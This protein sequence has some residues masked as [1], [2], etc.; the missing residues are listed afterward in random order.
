MSGAATSRR[1]APPEAGPPP[2]RVRRALGITLI[3]GASLSFAL[4]DTN[5]KYLGQ[6][7]PVVTILW[8]RYAVQALV[9]AVWLGV[10]QA[11]SGRRM[12]VTAHPRFQALRGSLLLLCSALLFLGVQHMPVAEYTAV[13]M[14]TP[15]VATV[16][17]A[18]FLHE[19]LT[20][21]RAALVV[22]GFAGALTIV[23]PGSALFGWFLVFPLTMTLA[24]AVFQLLTRKLAGLE[25]PLTTHF[26]TG[27]VGGVVMTAVMAV[28]PGDTWRALAAAT[29]PQAGLVLFAGLA[30]TLGHLCLILALGMAPMAALMPFTY[31]QIAFAS[32][33][34]WVVFHHVPDGWAVTGMAIVA[35]C[36]AA[37]V[38][39][40]LRDAQHA[41]AAREDAAPIAD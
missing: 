30:G 10:L 11:R 16:L 40:N 23:R 5:A 35:A 26:Y 28:A 18:L 29:P 32:L 4:L 14:L 6:H 37:A 9:M 21:L 13:G 12:F 20:P 34:G 31:T 19:R 15:V 3:L 17:A 24:Y 1:A 27:L 2:P 8:G 33:A 41:R 38:W 22:G 7:L 36:G 39:L 25:H